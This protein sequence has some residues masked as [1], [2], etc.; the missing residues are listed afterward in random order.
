MSQLLGQTQVLQ[1]AV[2]QY[3]GHYDAYVAQY[4][5]ILWVYNEYAYQDLGQMGICRVCVRVGC[6][7]YGPTHRQLVPTLCQRDIRR[8]DMRLP[9]CREPR[10]QRPIDVA[11]RLYGEVQWR[12]CGAVLNMC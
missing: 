8:A 12:D 11:K 9:P 4:R 10:L 3:A 5:N 6:L 1:E 2:E 7:G